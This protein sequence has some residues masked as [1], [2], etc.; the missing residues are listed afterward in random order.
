MVPAETSSSVSDLDPIAKFHIPIGIPN[1]VDTLKSFVEAEGDFSPGFATYGMYAWVR[2]GQGKLHAA[3]Q[4]DSG[5]THG[6]ADGGFLIPWAAWQA[7]PLKVRTEVCQTAQN[8]PA[9]ELQVLAMRIALTNPSNVVAHDSLFLAIRALGPA[10]WPIKAMSTADGD[11]LLVENHPAL[12]A[13]TKPRALG[14]AGED[15]VGELA[16]TG[17]VPNQASASSIDGN[18]SGA[19]RFDLDIPAQGTVTVGAICPV[20]AGR[21]AVGHKWQPGGS[22][23]NF[24]EAAIFNPAEGGQLQPDPDGAWYHTL[25]VDDL[26][27]QASDYW[28]SKV[29]GV[30]L[31]L[32]DQKWS[33]GFTA[34]VSHLA[35]NLN[36]GAPD[37]AVINYTTFNRDGMY[38]AECL[39][40]AGIDDWSEQVIDYLYAHPFNGRDFPEADNPGQI[41]W[42]TGQ[43]WYYTHDQVWLQKILPQVEQLASLIR[44]CRTTPTP[45]WVDMNGLE[46]GDAVAAE[47]RRELKPGC[48]DG[49]HPIY[50]DAYDVAGLRAAAMLC[51]AAN[52]SQDAGQW[53]ALADQLMKGYDQKYGSNLAANYGSYSVLWP[54]RLYPLETGKAHDK[55]AGIG[56]TPVSSW[57]YFGSAT[58]HQ[59]L[60][61]GNRSAGFGTLALAF[62]HPQ[63][64]GWFAFDEFGAS[65][66]GGW[67]APLRTRWKKT[68][69][70]P[71]GWAIAEVALLLRDSLVFEDGERLV[72]MGGV[73]ETWFRDPHGLSVGHLPT[74]FGKLDFTY[75]LVN[76]QGILTLSNS[77]KPPDGY[78]WRLPKTGIR[79]IKCG[80]QILQ[81]LANGDVHLP[82][83]TTRVALEFDP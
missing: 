14:V 53:S 7:G 67:D 45:H 64:Q 72:L 47:K 20:M 46:F 12:V 36:T 68:S 37:V 62:Q 76:G 16:K 70:M 6:L 29:G 80:D 26:F 10:G 13:E 23:H 56:Q 54:C 5:C 34:M 59:G 57:P 24:R 28:R 71:H 39:Q 66:E 42:V 69:A 25:K 3:T 73:P 31:S 55:F 43:H 82:P 81:P 2:D 77:A 50:T 21:R 51:A 48:C 4:P 18:C 49:F 44:Y 17:E 40:R 78:L 15:S 9:G 63:M 75:E 83:G 11:A 22:N 38:I 32:P 58:A 19:M 27:R 8:S 65:A 30:E 33:D 52:D 74:Y 79:T 35:M 61:A 60:L 1:S 41:L